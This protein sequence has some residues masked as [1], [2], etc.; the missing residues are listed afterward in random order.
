MR[1]QIL[2]TDDLGEEEVKI[3]KACDG[4][5]ESVLRIKNMLEAAVK[6]VKGA[7]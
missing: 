3:D 4:S 1:V 6:I 5:N 2:V 7:R